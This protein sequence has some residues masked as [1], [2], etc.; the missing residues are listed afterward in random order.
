MKFDTSVDATVGSSSDPCLSCNSLS[1][2]QA[3]LVEFVR[4]LGSYSNSLERGSF[5]VDERKTRQEAQLLMNLLTSANIN[6]KRKIVTYSTKP[7]SVNETN[8]SWTVEKLLRPTTHKNSFRFTCPSLSL[9]TNAGTA[10]ERLPTN[11]VDDDASSPILLGRPLTVDDPDALRLSAD[12]M[13]RNI[14]NSFQKAIDARVLVWIE[15]LATKLLQTENHMVQTGAELEDVKVLLTTSEAALIRQ[16]RKAGTDISVT[17]VHTSFQVLT[18]RIDVS[19]DGRPPEAKKQCIRKGEALETVQSVL[20]EQDDYHY[21]VLHCLIF[22]STIY[23]TTPAGFSEISIEVPGVIEG[24]F[25]SSSSVPGKLCS[26]KV[27]VDTSILAAMLEKSCRTVVRASVEACLD[28]EDI[29]NSPKFAMAIEN[30]AN[31]CTPRI[32]TPAIGSSFPSHI[33]SVEEPRVLITPLSTDELLSE[34]KYRHSS[35]ASL[36]M[37]IPDDLSETISGEAM[38]HLISP[39]PSCRPELASP[40][41]HQGGP[42]SLLPRQ[43]VFQPSL[44]NFKT[45]DQCARNNV[46]NPCRLPLIS[47]LSSESD[48]CDVS[49]GV[50]P[51]LPN[52]PRLGDTNP[53]LP[54][55]VEAACRAMETG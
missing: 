42:T 20:E 24:T 39:H 15:A 6:S 14:S 34:E 48:Y 54:L 7:L 1:Y 51:L 2:E 36:L 30:F 12:A 28:V 5:I 38:T 50:G 23:L 13:A 29:E 44:E 53:S 47:P 37:P 4:C 33:C 41:A 11:T 32:L 18:E 16:L 43:H 49:L 55:L 31:L 35:S 26:V 21:T 3:L 40:G 25:F 45:Y 8:Q 27:N 17:G 10:P 46:S 52:C 19:R 9:E 22:Q